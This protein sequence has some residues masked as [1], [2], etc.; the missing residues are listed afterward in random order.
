[1]LVSYPNRFLECA[2][3]IGSKLRLN[4]IRA[5][6]VYIVFC[7]FL[8]SC[9]IYPWS[10]LDYIDCL[11]FA[12]GS[13]TQSGISP[14]DLSCLRVFQQGILWLIVLVTNPIFIHSLLVLAR[15]YHFQKRFRSVSDEEKAKRQLYTRRAPALQKRPKS[16]GTMTSAVMDRFESSREGS[17][18]CKRAEMVQLS[19]TSSGMREIQKMVYGPGGNSLDDDQISTSSSDLARFIAPALN[20]SLP[21][22]RCGF[23]EVKP[24]PP[25]T[26][27]EGKREG[28]E[29]QPLLAGLADSRRRNEAGPLNRTTLAFD[30][31]SEPFTK[32]GEHEHGNSL[33]A[34][35]DVE[36]SGDCLLQE[37]CFYSDLPPLM[38]HSTFVSYS[39]WDE[40]KKDRIGGIEYRAL[41]TL[42][43]ILAGFLVTFHVIGFLALI[44]WLHRNPEYE[45]IIHDAGANRYWWAI[46]TA[47]SAF[48]NVGYTLTPD[49]MV[50]FEGATLPL[51]TMSFLVVVGNTGFPCML[52]FTIWLLSKMSHW[53]SP[54][55]EELQFLLDHPRRC[56]TMLFPRDETWR[57]AFVLLA[58][59]V[60]D[61][62]VMLVLGVSGASV[63]GDNGPELIRGE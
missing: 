2:F 53:R 7:T 45:S 9:M 26:D 57:L 50:S 43:F 49:S 10:G 20:F 24:E 22:Q 58:L 28:Q 32:S 16:Y 30:L 25:Y 17:I 38:L 42:L 29:Q 13:A 12:A 4:F 41:K 39:D 31:P 1:M 44:T 36:A 19:E 60:V 33:L 47:G 40:T 11:L 23:E 55:W 48:H 37:P 34:S 52:R 63:Y 61:L 3:S 6:Y 5:H 59:N 18:S 27:N 21:L 54:L 14:L 62:I 51:L 46:F 8:A 56:F 15:L 35:D